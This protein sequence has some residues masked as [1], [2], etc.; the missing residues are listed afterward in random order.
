MT[1]D[2]QLVEVRSQPSAVVRAAR[3]RTEDIA[4]FLGGVFSEVMAVLGRQG[5]APVGPPFS[6]Y[7]VSDDG[8][9]VEAGFPTSRAIEATGRVVP[10]E[11]PG[12]TVATTTHTGAYDRID[13]AYSA[14]TSW[15]AD[16]RLVASATPWESYL[17]GPDVPEPRTEVFVPCR[18]VEAESGD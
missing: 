17:D 12:G 5:L 18:A 15:L 16:H 7:V 1:Y 13:A 4:G 6:R 10:G 14:A 2:V 9:E 8:F 3:V 11:L